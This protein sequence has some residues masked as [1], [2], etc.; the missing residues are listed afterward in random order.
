MTLSAVTISPLP[1]VESALMFA[2]V[3]LH[4]EVRFVTVM[5][6]GQLNMLTAR[7]NRVSGA[8]RHFVDTAVVDIDVWGFRSRSMDVSIAARDIQASILGL[9]GQ[10]VTNGVIQHVV[11]ISGPRA[12]PEVNQT[13]ARYNASYQ[14]RLHAI[15]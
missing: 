11:T 1:D 7:I 6:A 9:L 15:P 14:V 2:L 13:L 5:P 3:P 8:E 12:M 10:V 4:P